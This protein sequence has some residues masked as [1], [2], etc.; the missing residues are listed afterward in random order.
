MT[1]HRRDLKNE[2]L[3]S[4]PT[5]GGQHKSHVC[6]L[7]QVRDCCQ[8]TGFVLAKKGA[9]VGATLCQC[10]K[11]CKVCLGQARKVTEKGTVLCRQP[12]PPRIV[13]IINGAGIPARYHASGLKAFTNH[14]G[15]SREV[16]QQLSRWLD[17]FSPNDNQKGII[18]EGPVGVGKTYL[19]AA[20]AKELA[21][22]G[23][24]VKF[25]DFFQLLNK[26]KAYYATSTKM[27]E[28]PIEPLINVDVLFIDEL[29]KGRSTDFEFA[30]IDQLV[31]GRYNQNKVIVAST[32]FRTRM[33]ARTSRPA[34]N[35]SGFEN[36]AGRSGFNLDQNDTLCNRVGERI[37]SRLMETSIVMEMTGED[38][39]MNAH[40]KQ[41]VNRT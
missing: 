33:E 8:G 10:V 1:K 31:M 3:N 28:D 14:T 41:P 27:E 30:V 6:A 24:E 26:L 12:S 32:N 21:Y 35:P 13:N 19:L 17:T 18:L 39:R 23:I 15:N 4:R 22:R 40:K 25:I 38:F 9:I 11:D 37:Y 36:M 7:D 5:S 16:L 2:L 34:G 20:L 29:G